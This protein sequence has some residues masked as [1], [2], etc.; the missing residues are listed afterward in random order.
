MSRPSGRTD[1]A[2]AVDRQLAAET[3]RSCALR[4]ACTTAVDGRSISLYPA[5]SCAPQESRM[6][7][8]VRLSAPIYQSV[9]RLLLADHERYS[10]ARAFIE[11]AFGFRLIICTRPLKGSAVYMFPS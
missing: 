6:S 5:E 9:P 10:G 4:D 8:R 3:C 2:G 11:S 1:S 7:L